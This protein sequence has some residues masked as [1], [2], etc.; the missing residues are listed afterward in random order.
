MFMMSRMIR[1]TMIS[2]F[3][4]ALAGNGAFAQE[5]PEE[6]GTEEGATEGAP[7]EGGGEA[8]PAE[9]GGEEGGMAEGTDMGG[10]PPMILAKGKLAVHAAIGINLSK[11]AVAKPIVVAPDVWYGLM[12][13]LEVGVVHSNMGLTGWWSNGGGGSLC[14]GGTERG[15]AKL[16]NGPV[17]VLAHYS[18]MEGNIDLA[19]DGGVVIAALDPELLLGLK[20]GV[21][22]RWM[23]GKIGV[24]FQPNIYIGLTKRDFN[25]EA[26]SIPVMVGYMVSPKLHAGVQTGITGPL[27][28]FGDFYRIPV[29]VGAMFMVNPTLGVAGSFNFF[30]LA[31]KGSSADGRDLT[32]SVM[33]HN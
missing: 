22:G 32:I 2:V 17:G 25:K 28:H 12:P 8:T 11:E 33:W 3:G 1:Y 24:F 19:A 31:G 14:L 30:N 27:S 13:K 10:K 16:Y 5:T 7:A 26:I 21:M 6:G 15:C 23:S 4:L 18:V 9:G 29:G 20:V